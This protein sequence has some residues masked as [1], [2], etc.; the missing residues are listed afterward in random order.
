MNFRKPLPVSRLKHACRRKDFP[1]GRRVAP[2]CSQVT[3]LS[4]CDP[5]NDDPEAGYRRG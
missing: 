1:C 3:G 5:G 4:S 2:A